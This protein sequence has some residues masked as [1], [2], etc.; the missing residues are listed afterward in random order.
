MPHSVLGSRDDGAQRCGLQPHYGPTGA[1]HPPV[2][3]KQRPVGGAVEHTRDRARWTRREAPRTPAAA[4]YPSTDYNP[5]F[6][7]AVATRTGSG[8][9][10]HPPAA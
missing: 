4:D 9:S 1:A 3:P 6:E 2:A 7:P 8:T 5:A 10:S